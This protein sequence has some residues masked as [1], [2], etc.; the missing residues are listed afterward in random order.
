MVNLQDGQASP[1]EPE[2]PI[3]DVVS[4][5]A[6]SRLKEVQQVMQ[7]ASEKAEGHRAEEVLKE[8][9][10]KV[11]DAAMGQVEGGGEAKGDEAA[12]QEAV[13]EDALGAENGEA[14]TKAEV[15]E[16]GVEEEGEGEAMGATGGDTVVGGEQVFAEVGTFKDVAEEGDGV[17]KGKAVTAAGSTEEATAGVENGHRDGV[18]IVNEYLRTEV[19]QVVEE[20]VIALEEMGRDLTTSRTEEEEDISEQAVVSKEKGAAEKETHETEETVVKV[21]LGGEQETVETSDP[22]LVVASVIEQIEAIGGKEENLVEDTQVDSDDIETTHTVL[23]EQV[24]EEEEEVIR[25]NHA[26]GSEVENK[27]GPEMVEGVVAGEE[28]V[29]G[30]IVA[31]AAGRDSEEDSEASEKMVHGEGEQRAREEAHAALETSQGT[32]TENQGEL[33]SCKKMLE[34][35]LTAW[36]SELHKQCLKDPQQIKWTK[37][38]LHY[39]TF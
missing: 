2:V 6:P 34:S 26:E 10:E 8:L 23:G 29:Q 25:E 24:E 1:Q 35:K 7:E 3:T 11:V 17:V 21:A 16:Q 39:L 4:I 14:D 19:S 9:L 30:T 18:E 32:E 31:K 27:P 13:T 28:V 15:L 37:Y 20:T 22:S 5:M 38:Q 12:V 33:R 36:S